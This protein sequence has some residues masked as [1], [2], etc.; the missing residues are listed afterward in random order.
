MRAR[1]ICACLALMGAGILRAMI[2][3]T[4]WLPAGNGSNAA[5][6]GNSPLRT[7]VRAALT[8]DRIVDGPTSSA[9]IGLICAVMLAYI[10]ARP[11]IVRARSAFRA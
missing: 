8:P 6:G 9:V 5:G 11:H 1:I 3:V 10:V 2:G 7:L 4:A